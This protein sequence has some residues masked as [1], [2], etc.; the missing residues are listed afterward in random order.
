MGFKK[1]QNMSLGHTTTMYF[2]EQQEDQ[3]YSDKTQLLMK[4]LDEIAKKSMQMRRETERLRKLKEEAKQK[5][6]EN[7]PHLFKNNIFQLEGMSNS[8]HIRF[9]EDELERS[10]TSF[11]SG[12]MTKSEGDET[13]I[14]FENRHKFRHLPKNFNYMSK[15]MQEVYKSLVASNQWT[16]N[17]SDC[18]DLDSVKLK[19]RIDKLKYPKEAWLYQKSQ[20]EIEEGT[21]N[22][23]L[24]R[25]LK[26]FDREQLPADGIESQATMNNGLAAS[27]VSLIF[28]I[29]RDHVSGKWTPSPHRGGMTHFVKLPHY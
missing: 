15:E 27:A 20:I 3:I 19:K 22:G 17:F 8:E 21:G 12:D 26:M 28:L 23:P 10:D 7:F 16:S 4:R 25:L 6:K 5:V 9:S 18:S 29:R 2:P 13:A 24:G 14:G 11:S 1:S